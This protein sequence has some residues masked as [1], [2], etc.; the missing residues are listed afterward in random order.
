M[1]ATQGVHKSENFNKLIIFSERIEVQESLFNNSQ[2]LC[3]EQRN[4][5]SMKRYVPYYTD[6]FPLYSLRETILF[7]RKSNE[8]HSNLN[9]VKHDISSVYVYVCVTP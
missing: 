2:I 5:I 4:E 7:T 3:S 6:H 9:S 1:I 8:N